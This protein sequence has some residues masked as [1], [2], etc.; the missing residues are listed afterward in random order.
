[1]QLTELLI[2]ISDQRLLIRWRFDSAPFENARSAVDELL[3]PLSDLRRVDRESSPQFAARRRLIQ[4]RQSDLRLE[5]R[6]MPLPLRS[7]STF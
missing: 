3:L 5:A 6:A 7:R 2:K 4:S 1:M